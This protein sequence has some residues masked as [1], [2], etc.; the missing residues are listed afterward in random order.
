MTDPRL[1][2]AVTL[3]HFGVIDNLSALE[4]LL[5]GYSQPYWTET[6]RSEILAMTAHSQRAWRQDCS[7]VCVI[8]LITTRREQPL[9]R[10]TCCSES[11][12]IEE[13]FLPYL[14]NYGL[15]I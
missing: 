3:R 13:E 7:K 1:V 5:S 10:G 15:G 4:H 11:D 6:V 9:H 12:A 2:D 8:P 14:V